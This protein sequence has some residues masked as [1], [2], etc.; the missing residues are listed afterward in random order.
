MPEKFLVTGG[1]GFIGS[2]IVDELINLGE[3]PIV[4]DDLSTGDRANLS[5]DVIFYQCDVRNKDQQSWP[6]RSTLS[7]TKKNMV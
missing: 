5:S 1:A 3:I 4:V 6:V 2:N 7:S